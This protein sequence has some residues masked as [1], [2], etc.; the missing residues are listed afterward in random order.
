MSRALLIAA[1]VAGLAAGGASAAPRSA[2][3]KDP[4]TRA[5]WRIAEALSSDAMEGRDIGSPGFDRAAD[6]VVA[7]FK[8]AGLRPAGDNGGWFQVFPVHESRVDA[9][10]LIAT[11]P[12]GHVANL[13]FLR[14]FSV[15]AADDLPPT[16]EGPVMWG[17]YCRSQDL[18]AARG[19]W[20]VCL[21]SR[22]A[23]RT[24]G[25]QRIANA[26]TAGAVGLIHL[27]DPNFT[28]EPAR[29]PAA[30]ARTVTLADRPPPQTHAF[31]VLTLD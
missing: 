28:I 17:G 21:N 18:A 15:R 8:A 11:A 27:D 29:W 20:V 7:R 23:G 31:P 2:G 24:T 3:I 4:D 6:V 19:K 13:A 14:Q 12:N 30:Y 9:A 1:A 25:A 5:W 26:Q 22:R 10:A 16:A